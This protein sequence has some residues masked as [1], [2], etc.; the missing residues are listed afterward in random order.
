M[1]HWWIGLRRRAEA[2]VRRCSLRRQGPDGPRVTLASR[3]IYIVPTPAGG[4]F[5]AMLATMLAGAMNYNNNLGFALA[6]L[7]TGVG[8]A[9]I[10]QTHRHLLGLRISYLGAEPV[11]AG[12]PLAVRFRLENG[13]AE[14]RDELRLAWPEA[15]EVPGGL[16]AGESRLVALPLPTTRR[17][18]QPLPALRI[19]TTAPLGLM[20]AWTWVQLDMAL[21]VWPAA[22]PYAAPAAPHTAGAAGDR[23]QTDGDD[24]SGLRGYQPGDNQRRIAWRQSARLDEL[25][26]REFRDAGQTSHWFDWAREPAAEVETR[27][28][29][30]TRRVLDADAAGLR[31]GLSLPGSR[32]GPGTGREQLS[33]ALQALAL[34]EPAG[35]SP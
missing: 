11:F 26:V 3:R 8:L 33:A 23:H 30:L 20:R 32:I 31:W 16:R 34:L 13:S 4:I 5:A 10:Y 1:R 21:L 24:Y 28:A 9:A 6:F 7:L 15:Q 27:I 35:A 12:A 2:R 22:A 14:P 17:G 25:V 19:A 18:H 29:R